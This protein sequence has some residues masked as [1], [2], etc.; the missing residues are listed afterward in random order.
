MS[1]S[2]ERAV[3]RAIR[4]VLLPVIELPAFQARLAAAM[5]AEL[6]AVAAPPVRPV[7]AEASLAPEQPKAA[8]PA[9]ATAAEAVDAPPKSRGRQR[10]SLSPEER[11][12]KARER[13]RE[14][15]RKKYVSVRV[16]KVQTDTV[17][18]P[19]PPPMRTPLP[20][21]AQAEV[22]EAASPKQLRAWLVERLYAGGATRLDATD[23]VA[24]MTHDQ[25]L[26][27]AN[28]RCSR[29]GARPFRLV[30]PAT[31]ALTPSRQA[32]A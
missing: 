9:S 7:A 21:P 23:R 1:A 3:R 22:P 30:M 31:R 4:Q 5:A 27:E 14:W 12:T 18:P 13:K 8:T 24:F 29:M 11:A 32:W 28:L 10:S 16:P 15:A 25:V 19:T 6:V 20:A 2:I 26:T 17:A